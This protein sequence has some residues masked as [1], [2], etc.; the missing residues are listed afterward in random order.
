MKK[1]ITAIV[2]AAGKGSRMNSDI[3]KQFMLL[4]D[5]PLL[6]YSLNTFQDSIVDNIILVVSENHISYC[7][8]Q[9]VDKYNFT[10]VDK[11][12]AGGKERYNSVYEGL[13]STKDT[14]YVVI[15]DGAR[16]FVTKD[17][18]EKCIEVLES[19]DGCTVGMPVKDTIKVVNENTEGIDTPNRESLWQIQTPQTFKKDKLLE[20]YDKM[21]SDNYGNI[22]DDTMIMER[23]NTSKIKVLKGDYTNI[24]ITTPEDLKIAEIF[25]KKLLTLE[26]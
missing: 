16:P 23:Y 2:L 14:D 5:K 24:K 21:F 18:I 9:I 19:Y 8:E 17:M 11:I 15:H 7:Q 4:E 22:T 1:K 6:Y 3:E 13:T 26:D 12:V 20:A 25:L 10:K